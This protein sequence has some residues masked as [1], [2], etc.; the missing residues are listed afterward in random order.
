[1]NKSVLFFGGLACL[2]ALIGVA[3]G[4]Q[5][6]GRERLPSCDENPQAF[7]EALSACTPYSCQ[8][9]HPFDK[10]NHTRVVSGLKDGRCNYSETMPNSGNMRCIMDDQTAR[11]L[12]EEHKFWYEMRQRAR[13]QGQ[14]FGTRSGF[15]PNGS[16]SIAVIGDE[17]F[18]AP[19]GIQ[20]ATDNGQCEILGYD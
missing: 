10:R 2:I 15:G 4:L 6:F 20:M 14:S 7:V 11:A 18:E 3:F 13:E 12:A 1:M 19:G 16:Y 5:H 17:E 9:K 8:F